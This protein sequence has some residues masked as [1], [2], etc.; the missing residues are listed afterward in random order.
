[1]AMDTSKLVKQLQRVGHQCRTT[2]PELRALR[3][4][5]AT[6]AC[7]GQGQRLAGGPVDRCDRGAHVRFI[8][9]SSLPRGF[10]PNAKGG[11]GQSLFSLGI[12]MFPAQRFTYQRPK[13]WGRGP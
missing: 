9:N 1:M 6:P 7:G 10:T 3:G 13:S 2:N 12:S 5:E 8:L 4:E 11:S